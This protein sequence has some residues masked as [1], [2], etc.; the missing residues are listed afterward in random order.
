MYSQTR[1]KFTCIVRLGANLILCMIKS[2]P[3]VYEAIWMR[4]KKQTWTNDWYYQQ[5]IA[6]FSNNCIMLCIRRAVTFYCVSKVK[7]HSTLHLN[8]KWQNLWLNNKEISFKMHPY[9]L[10]ITNSILIYTP[11]ASACEYK[12]AFTLW[13]HTLCMCKIYSH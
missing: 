6:S 4:S 1:C 12:I 10:E 7:Y 9:C 5:D 13:E 11:F 3:G 8:K 2:T